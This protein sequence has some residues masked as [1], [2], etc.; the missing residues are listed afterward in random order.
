[1]CHAVIINI[2][3]IHN[4]TFRAFLKGFEN[5]NLHNAHWYHYVDRPLCELAY[6]SWAKMHVLIMP[7]SY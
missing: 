4:F 3:A 2:S 7:I 6:V 1:M 5:S